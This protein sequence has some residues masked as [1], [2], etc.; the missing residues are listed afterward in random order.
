MTTKLKHRDTAILL[1]IFGGG[2]GVHKLYLHQYRHA[3]LYFLFVWTNIPFFLSIYDIIKY[4]GQSRPSF[5]A[6]YDIHS[7]HDTI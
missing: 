5:H 4:W 6:Q 7:Y 3:L 1:A 2:F